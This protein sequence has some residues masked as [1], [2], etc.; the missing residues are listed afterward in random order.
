MD[1]TRVRWYAIRS[2]PH[3]EVFLY[4]QLTA[5]GI[6][7]F[8][9]T[10][11]VKPVNP[12]SRTEVPYFP[13]YMFIH[14]DMAQTGTRTLDRIP[15][16]VGLVHFGD[17]A[18][19]IPD[20]IIHEIKQRI[21]ARGELDRNRIMEFQHGD[22]VKI[23]QGPMKGYVAIFDTYLQGHERVKVLLEMM[24]DRKVAIELDNDMID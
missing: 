2:K 24:S 23:T 1:E 3:H 22:R 21:I 7:V 17:E 5:R 4:Q 13:G 18:P 11:K 8:Y 19:W 10:I 20:I 12:R 16:S 15:G 9:P 14:L 6:E